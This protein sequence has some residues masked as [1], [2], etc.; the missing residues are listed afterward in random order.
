MLQKLHSEMPSGA[1]EDDNPDYAEKCLTPKALVGFKGTAKRAW[2]AGGN[3]SNNIEMLYA[4]PTETSGGISSCILLPTLERDTIGFFFYPMIN[5]SQKRKRTSFMPPKRKRKTKDLALQDSVSDE[6]ESE[7]S[8]QRRPN[9]KRKS[10][11]VPGIINF[12]KALE[13]PIVNTSIVRRSLRIQRGVTQP[14]SQSSQDSLV[15]LPTPADSNDTSPQSDIQPVLETGLKIPTQDQGNL[16]SQTL[17]PTTVVPGSELESSN[18]GK[19]NEHGTSTIE[20]SRSAG[21]EVVPSIDTEQNAEQC[22]TL[23]DNITMTGRTSQETE[24][25]RQILPPSGIEM[26]LN[27][28]LEPL[29][30]STSECSFSQTSPNSPRLA[31]SDLGET[32]SNDSL[33]QFPHID[34]GSSSSS[35]STFN[36]PPSDDNDVQRIVGTLAAAEISP[37][38][39]EGSVSPVLSLL[40]SLSSPSSTPPESPEPLSPAERLEQARR[41]IVPH[42]IQRSLNPPRDLYGVQAGRNGMPEHVT[43]AVVT[44]SRKHSVPMIKTE[45]RFGFLRNPSPLCG[46]TSLPKLLPRVRKMRGPDYLHKPTLKQRTEANPKMRKAR[47]MVD[48]ITTRQNE[49]VQ[50][51]IEAQR[52]PRLASILEG[53]IPSIIGDISH[54]GNP[55]VLKHPL[56]TLA[57]LQGTE[58]PSISPSLEPQL[59]Q[60]ASPES[61]NPTPEAGTQDSENPLGAAASAVTENSSVVA[62]ASENSLASGTTTTFHHKA[63]RVAALIREYELA[64]AATPASGLASGVAIVREHPLAAA[65]TTA[66]GLPL[67]RTIV[68]QHPLAA[69]TTPPSNEPWSSVVRRN[70][71][72][73]IDVDPASTVSFLDSGNCAPNVI[74][75]V[76]EGL[77][78]ERSPSFTEDES[79]EDERIPSGWSSDFSW[80]SSSPST[81]E[82]RT[83]SGLQRRPVGDFRWVDENAIASSEPEEDN[84]DCDMEN[85]EEQQCF[86]NILLYD[87]KS[88]RKSYRRTASKYLKLAFIQK[89]VIFRHV[90]LYK[91]SRIRPRRRTACTTSKAA[92]PTAPPSNPPAPSPILD[93]ER[94]PFLITSPPVNGYVPIR[95]ALPFPKNPK[96]LKTGSP[97]FPV[98]VQAQYYYQ[99][100]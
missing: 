75:G 7:R 17:S 100:R 39:S 94:R 90:E 98:P 12:R 4:P 97:Y 34:R 85:K 84:E 18:E 44:T 24:I 52:L 40:S 51:R 76:N 96:N 9:V 10:T 33:Q 66:P 27:T 48:I 77:S 62:S 65:T 73:G 23:Q 42:I 49:E 26:L 93:P 86:K 41:E 8:S 38:F 61:E 19:D 36:Q 60:G 35:S 83:L 72:I 43:V 5:E 71:R 32:R 70:L 29:V 69:A 63:A 67:A 25:I 88:K 6:T 54:I 82:R 30:A 74:P 22:V 57:R 87:F 79:T 91:R 3:E 89:H 15:A 2:D 78:A 37:S 99:G 50:K 11:T 58:L 46:P 45:D 80:L 13:D 16:D 55:L 21:H 64:A 95:T 68:P 1:T 31:G 59:F 28:P 53:H 56:A 14:L 20:P 81:P 47:M 92:N